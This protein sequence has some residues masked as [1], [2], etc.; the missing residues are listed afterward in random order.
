MSHSIAF[1]GAGN[2]A[3][4]IIGGMVQQGTDPNLITATAPSLSGLDS[5]KAQFGIHV[6]Q[7]NTFA[8][9]PADIV[10]LAVKPQK[11]QQVCSDIRHSIKADSLIIS[12][13]AGITCAS[14]QRWLGGN[15]A[16]VRCMPNTPSA[17]GQGA[18]GLFALAAVSK[19]QKIL[20]TQ[21]M[22]AVGI[23]EWVEDE[24]LIDAVTAVSGS[25]PA[26]FFLLLEAMIDAGV[27]QGLSRHTAQSL[28]IQTAAGAAELARQ[29]D[30]D[31]AEL[32]SR[33]TSPGGTTEQA[34]N[35]FEA[36][37]FRQI[38]Q[39]AME[40]CAQRAQQLAKQLGE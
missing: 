14:L 34:I 13:A 3:R 35:S 24:A 1:I 8:A 18:S 2:M 29:S 16:I 12:V 21:L 26:Y 15:R 6:S 30:V 10:V 4:S 28:A 39:S 22:Q 25:G 36:N 27:K 17:V 5:L 7:N 32:R 11:M 37:G 20:A 38:V 40:A 9:K 33:V 31:L 23:V 19:R